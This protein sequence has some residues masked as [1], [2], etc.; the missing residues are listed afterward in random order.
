MN[1]IK[2]YRVLDW[3]YYLGFI[4]IGFS[5]RSTLNL[6][7]IIYILLGASLLAYA[8]SLND[9]YDKHEKKKFFVLPFILSFLLFPFFNVI[10]IIVSLIFL[11][12][13][14]FYSVYP[15]R[16]KSK[17]T[18]S[19]LCNGFGFTII[20][21][22]GYFYKPTLYLDGVLFSLLFFSFNM[23]AQIIHEFVHIK[24]DKKN[25]I[26]TIA[27]FYGEKTGRY[28]CY[29][30]LLLSLFIV[31]YLFYMKYIGILFFVSVTFFI[32]FFIRG[33]YK[34]TINDQF[35]KNYRILGILIGFIY[36]ISLYWNVCL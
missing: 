12:I 27:V 23:I 18:I 11:L 32:T 22:L 36:F 24:E 3:Y 5:L 35:R 4:L 7:I 13:V 14:T 29:L 10:Q 15:F 25:K 30:F 33:I 6:D 31:Y 34:N 1:I 28:L 16:W 17:P 9:F 8:Y 21:L 19:S 20:F 26:M 2:I